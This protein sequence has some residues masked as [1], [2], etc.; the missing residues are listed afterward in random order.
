MSNHIH[1]L[2]TPEVPLPE[3]TKSLK[4]ITAKR[5]NLMLSL[6]QPDEGVRRRRERPPLNVWES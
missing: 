5:A 2:T 6:A 1:L 3:L 4:G